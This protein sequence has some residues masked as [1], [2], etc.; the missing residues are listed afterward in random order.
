MQTKDITIRQVK[1][2]SI[3]DALLYGFKKTNEHILL[4]LSIELVFFCIWFTIALAG[5]TI[6]GI[7]DKIADPDFL[8][9]LIY[10][11]GALIHHLIPLSIK[12]KVIFG[13][14]LLVISLFFGG[15]VLLQGVRRI[16]LDIYDKNESSLTQI[17]SQLGVFSVI[18]LSK[19]LYF[20]AVLSGS[21]CLILPGIYLSAKYGFYA[22]CLLDDQTL[23]PVEAF[24]KSGQLTK[25]Y[26]NH[27]CVYNIL[28]TI[29]LFLSI[30]L[31]VAWIIIIP[32][33][34]LADAYI[35]RQI[36]QNETE[37]N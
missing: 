29:L 26:V 30:L 9:E 18:L 25:G 33:L 10:A 35:Y 28:W 1:D 6:E 24:K 4:I 5:A 3:K 7:P 34:M 13:L 12:G 17:Y 8:Q 27:L 22:Y 2:F 14:N 16:M 23:G 31:W 15:L 19:I 20:V 11:L 36:T 21:I 32:V 37:I